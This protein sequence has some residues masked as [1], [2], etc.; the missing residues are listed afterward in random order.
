MVKK[1]T[2]TENPHDNVNYNIEQNAQAANKQ[3]NDESQC[4]V[5]SSSFAI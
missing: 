2:E 5:F 4:A 1:E 3:S